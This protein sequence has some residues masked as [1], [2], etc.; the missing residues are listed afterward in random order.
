[1][2]W[3]VETMHWLLDVHFDEDFCRVGERNVQQNLNIVRKVAL[4][5]I[6]GYK[7]KTACKRPISKLMFDCLLESENILSVLAVNEN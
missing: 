6:K 2:E 7:N 4:N 1:M 3:P 5:T